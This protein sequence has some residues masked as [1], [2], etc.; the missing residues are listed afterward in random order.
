MPLPTDA[1]LYPEVFE[2]ILLWGGTLVWFFE[3]IYSFKV[4]LESATGLLR[5]TVAFV[6]DLLF[7]WN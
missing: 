5:K 2:G 3:E 7:L 6:F 4:V 1:V